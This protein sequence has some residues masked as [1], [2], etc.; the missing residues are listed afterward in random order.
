[1]EL[2]YATFPIFGGE[3]RRLY[4]EYRFVKT[5][6]RTDF[7]DNAPMYEIEKNISCFVLE[8]DE[9]ILAET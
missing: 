4:R 9:Y 5:I 1:M 2:T 6:T 8:E 3:E 7:S